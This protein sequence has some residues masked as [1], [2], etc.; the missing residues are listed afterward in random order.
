MNYVRCLR[1]AAE[2]VAFDQPDCFIII[3]DRKRHWL[4]H[5]ITEAGIDSYASEAHATEIAAL[6]AQAERLGL[7]HQTTLVVLTYKTMEE[8]PR[9]LAMY[10]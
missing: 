10:P 5:Q 6:H 4:A 7:P 8:L 2:H 9:R 3:D 1:G